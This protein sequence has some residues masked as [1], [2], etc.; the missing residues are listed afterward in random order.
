ML[1]NCQSVDVFEDMMG[2]IMRMMCFEVRL[3]RLFWKIFMCRKI[4]NLID[5]ANMVGIVVL[6]KMIA[7]VK[8]FT[9]GIIKIYILLKKMIFEKKIFHKNN[10]IIKSICF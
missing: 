4:I 1:T 8:L 9:Y 6:N 5:K 2:M 3:Q 10:V 7:L